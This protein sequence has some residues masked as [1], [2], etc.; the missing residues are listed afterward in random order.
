MQVYI[1]ITRF[2][3]VIE[4][5]GVSMKSNTS[6]FTGKAFLRFVLK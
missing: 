5:L 4:T 2:T 3:F 6:S 1:L